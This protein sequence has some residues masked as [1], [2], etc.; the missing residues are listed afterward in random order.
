MLGAGR[1]WCFEIFRFFRR[2][3]MRVV[4]WGMSDLGKPRVRIL[5]RGL[6]ENDIEWTISNLSK[7]GTADQRPV[8]SSPI[9]SPASIPLRLQQS[10]LLQQR[11][12]IRHVFI[13]C[14]I[15][16]R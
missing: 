2:F 1:N 5:E 16:R 14:R 3:F 8:D 15:L 7:P 9:D 6:R 13:K 11:P 10:L 12:R 4:M